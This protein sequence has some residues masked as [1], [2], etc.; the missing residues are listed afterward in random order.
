[1]LLPAV[2]LTLIYKYG[3]M[4]GVII[5]F[6]KFSPVKGIQGSPF[7]GFDNFRFALNLPMTERVV[8]NTLII[9]VGKIAIGLVAPLITALMLNDLSRNWSKRTIQTAIYLPHF[10]SWVILGGIMI[11]I[12][13]PS[14]GIVNA[15]L[16]HLGVHPIYFLGSNTWFQPTLI[17]SHVWKEFGFSTV[18]YLAALTS[19]DP[20]LYEAAQLDGASRFRQMINV[21][22]PGMRPIIILLATLSLGSV[23]DAGFEQVLVLYSPQVYPTGDIVDTL[24]YR[25]GLIQAQY[26][27]ATAIG[28]AKSLVSLVLI[29]VAYWSAYRF[30]RYRIF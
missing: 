17:I 11:E 7:I 4:F 12:L 3:A 28:L 22:L 6:Q 9:A 16:G 13:S 25:M 18:I 27:V 8:Q 24:V 1:M 29:S 15:A 30:A 21:T 2:I 14:R 26:G 20:A 23:L 19:I 5:A 10:L